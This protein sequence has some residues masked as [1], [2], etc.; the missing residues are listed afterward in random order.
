[1]SYVECMCVLHGI[2]RARGDLRVPSG[3]TSPFAG[4]APSPIFILVSSLFRVASSFILSCFESK[5]RLN[6]C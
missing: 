3:G 4:E 6:A 2:A 1:M 5:L